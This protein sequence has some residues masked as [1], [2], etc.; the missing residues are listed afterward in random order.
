M[1]IRLQ[2]P[3]PA[4]GY[5]YIV[6]TVNYRGNVVITASPSTAESVGLGIIGF[7]LVI[8]ILVFWAYVR[9]IRRAGYSGWWILI[10][11]VPLVNL[12]M[13]LVFAFKDWPIQRELAQLRAMAGQGGYRSGPPAVAGGY[14]P[15]VYGDWSRPGSSWPDDQPR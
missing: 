1:V 3:S 5:R 4:R 14:P 8:L 7:Y 10:A 2:I 9:I 11:V 12:V 15:Q 6:T 13:F